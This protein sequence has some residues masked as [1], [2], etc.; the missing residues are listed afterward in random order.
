MESVANRSL[1]RIPAN[2]EKYREIRE[3]GPR[4]CTD[5]L[6]IVAQSRGLLAPLCP[7]KQCAEQGIITHVSWEQHFP[8][9]GL[10]DH[11]IVWHSFLGCFIGK[12][13]CQSVVGA[14]CPFVPQLGFGK[15]LD[16][17]AADN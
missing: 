9:T 13:R 6:S 12:Y 5:E 8:D 14:C 7:F 11:A 3:F 1:E 17:D 10:P 16:V 4:V 15:E 2:R